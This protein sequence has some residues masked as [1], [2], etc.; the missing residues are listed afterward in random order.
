MH[1]SPQA[2]SRGMLKI[3]PI[4]LNKQSQDATVM[5]IREVLQRGIQLAEVCKHHSLV[6]STPPILSRC[7][8]MHLGRPLPMKHTCRRCSLGLI[9]RLL[10]KQTP[11]SRSLERPVS[12]QKSHE[13]YVSTGGRLR[14]SRTWIPTKKGLAENLGAAIHQ[15][16]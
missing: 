6:R 9:S 4:N 14:N 16:G 8:S 2:I 1:H 10:R 12:P 7:T 5:L 13:T 3:P 11:S 15:V